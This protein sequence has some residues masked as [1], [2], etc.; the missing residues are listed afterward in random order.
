TVLNSANTAVTWSISPQSGI[1]GT[2]GLYTAPGVVAGNTKVTVTAT[3][4]ADPTKTGAAT[5]TLSNLVDIGVGAPVDVQLQFLA[6][7]NRNGFANL[8]SL[9]PVANVK[10]LGTTGYVQEFNDAKTP[11]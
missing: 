8:V 5:V 10:R 3:S 9:P 6:A 1:I 4:A 7:F 11:G 2:G